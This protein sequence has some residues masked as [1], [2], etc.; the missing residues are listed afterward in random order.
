MM[1]MEA[2]YG[3]IEVT[4]DQDDEIRIEAGGIAITVTADE[5]WM[6]SRWVSFTESKIREWEKDD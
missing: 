5:F 3:P 4:L 2:K 1:G 6:I